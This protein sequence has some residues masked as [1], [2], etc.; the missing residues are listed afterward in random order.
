MKI[1]E[2]RQQDIQD[3][4][5]LFQKV[6]ALLDALR[7]ADPTIIEVVRFP[8]ARLWERKGHLLFFQHGSGRTIGFGQIERRERAVF[9]RVHEIS[10]LRSQKSPSLFQFNRGPDGDL[11][12]IATDIVDSFLR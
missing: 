11:E 4:R 1:R 12:A 7:A 9:G 5:A 8:D 2:D 10:I 3:Q 6:V